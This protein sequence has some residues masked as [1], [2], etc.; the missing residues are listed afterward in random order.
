MLFR[1]VCEGSTVKKGDRAMKSLRELA[2]DLTTAAQEKSHPPVPTSSVTT[3]AALAYMPSPDEFASV[4]ADFRRVRQEFERLYALTK[5]D[6]V[7]DRDRRRGTIQLELARLN[8]SEAR[9]DAA[10]RRLVASLHG[11]S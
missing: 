6:S 2:R 4:R 3:T 8:E 10:E 9:L 5:D 7:E 1:Q 11:R